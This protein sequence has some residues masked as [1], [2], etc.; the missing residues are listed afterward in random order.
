MFAYSA[1]LNPHESKWGVYHEL[2]SRLLSLVQVHLFV[3]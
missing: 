2:V 3:P 1:L